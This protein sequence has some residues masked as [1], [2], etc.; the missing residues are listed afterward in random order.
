[1]KRWIVTSSLVFSIAAGSLGCA[2]MTPAQQRA[3]SGGA[4]GAAAGAL[5]GGATGHAGTGAAIGGAT[6]A[7]G[8][9]IYEKSRGDDY[10]YYHHN[11]RYD[12]E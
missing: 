11:H 12:D 2:N 8:G 4:V 3:L 5:I 1:M 7:A 9:Y 10:D 6:G